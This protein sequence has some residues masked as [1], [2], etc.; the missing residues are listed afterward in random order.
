M[1][2][3]KPKTFTVKVP[4]YLK[5]V[6]QTQI[7]KYKLRRNNIVKPLC[8][9]CGVN[10]V[11]I[12]NEMREFVLSN[13]CRKCD[14]TMP[15][16]YFHNTSPLGFK[17]CQYSWYMDNVLNVPAEETTNEFLI[18]GSVSHALDEYFIDLLRKKWFTDKIKSLSPSR[19]GIYNFLLGLFKDKYEDIIKGIVKRSREEFASK[20]TEQELLVWRE[21]IF[22]NIINDYAYINAIRLLNDAMYNGEFTQL[23][24]QKHTE[25]VVFSTYEFFQIRLLLK[26]HI[27]KLYV[28]KNN[29]VFALRD[30][31]GRRAIRVNE[32]GMKFDCSEQ[33]GSY[34]LALKQ[35]YGKDV[36]NVG[37]MWLSRYWEPHPVICDEESYLDCLKEI[38]LFIRDKHSPTKSKPGGLCSKQ[39]CSRW[40]MCQNPS[41]Q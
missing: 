38:C 35:M 2:E 3:G 26:G 17:D 33:L 37:F 13:T 28:L 36:L 19:I 14:F 24:T 29:K 1:S 12:P 11:H 18:E 23:M 8:L 41:G 21:Q 16:L 34:S 7:A 20:I 30:D 39:F 10:Y 32:N 5:P 6:L 25:K 9:V 31:K 15:Y 4:E 40:E 22:H 27:D